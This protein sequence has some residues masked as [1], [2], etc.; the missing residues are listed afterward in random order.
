MKLP[1]FPTVPGWAQPSQRVAVNHAFCSAFPAL[2]RSWTRIQKLIMCLDLPD[3]VAATFY[4]RLPLVSNPSI[5]TSW[6]WDLLFTRHMDL[7][8]SKSKR[9]VACADAC[10][11]RR[12][13]RTFLA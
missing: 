12:R 7:D 11:S 1:C 3:D 8:L 9:S 2:L 5:T 4:F 10:V 13:G 6:W